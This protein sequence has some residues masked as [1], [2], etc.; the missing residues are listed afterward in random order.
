M[1][2]ALWTTVRAMAVLSVR[3]FDLNAKYASAR[4][5]GLQEFRIRL[6]RRGSDLDR[7]LIG[8][9]AFALEIRRRQYLDAQFSFF[10]H[11]HLRG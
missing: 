1:V 4:S 3:G 5:A 2:R 6:E 11:D 7:L 10:V 9:R 8:R